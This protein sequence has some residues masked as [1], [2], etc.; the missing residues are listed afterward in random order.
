M[1]T[2]KPKP[3]LIITILLIVLAL[4]STIS[5]LTSRTGF[6]RFA[7]RTNGANF[8]ANNGTGGA[9]G[10]FQGNNGAGGGTDNGNFQG[11]TGTGGTGGGNFQARGGSFNLFSIFRSLG[12]NP[13]L[14]GYISLGITI[15]G[16]V[17]VLLSAFGVWKQKTWG[18]NLAMVMAI[19]F[20]IGAVPAVFSFGG[21][22]VNL[23]R[24]S[25]TVLSIIAA[26]PILVYGILPSTRDF[27]T[28]R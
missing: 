5:V 23:L 7:G 27:V 20:L 17:L 16:I 8:Q 28:A 15:L 9:G 1:F 4:L 10:N 25:L 21:R 3:I 2:A 12:L 22:N 26:T 14:I 13:Q 18:L 24:E 19:I 6:V 11:N